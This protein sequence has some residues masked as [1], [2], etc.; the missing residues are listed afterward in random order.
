MQRSDTQEFTIVHFYSPHSN[1]VRV[2]SVLYVNNPLL[3]PELSIGAAQMTSVILE[4]Y[5]TLLL[6]G[7]YELIHTAL[8]LHFCGHRE[9]TTTFSRD[10]SD[11]NMSSPFSSMSQQTRAA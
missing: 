7:L 5:H 9:A 2:Y 6:T 11:Y 4:H 8:T 1:M 3:K 10:Y